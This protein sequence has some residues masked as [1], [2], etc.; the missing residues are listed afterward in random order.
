VAKEGEKEELIMRVWKKTTEKE[1]V[2]TGQF[3]KKMNGE[4]DLA[5]QISQARY[6]HF[7]TI[8]L[9]TV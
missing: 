1:E 8:T 5:I 3:E 2:E 6:F 4:E 9:A 7:V